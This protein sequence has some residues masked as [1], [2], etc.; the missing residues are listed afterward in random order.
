MITPLGLVHYVSLRRHFGVVV[1]L[2]LALGLA[3]FVFLHLLLIDVLVSLV[4]S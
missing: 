2:L 1:S 3:Y 4:V